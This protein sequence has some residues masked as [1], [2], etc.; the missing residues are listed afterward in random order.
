MLAL[1]PADK[2]FKADAA[3]KAHGCVATFQCPHCHYVR[4]IMAQI[5]SVDA[6]G[7]V[8][9]ALGPCRCGFNAEIRLIGW[10]A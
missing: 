1:I 6:Q 10:F 4:S 8:S 7:N 3:S 5:S 9:P 2:W